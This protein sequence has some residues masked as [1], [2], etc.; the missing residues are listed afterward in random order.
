MTCSTRHKSHCSGVCGWSGWR[1]P[2]QLSQ[3]TQAISFQSEKFIHS[4]PQA[5]GQRP[6][7]KGQRLAVELVLERQQSLFV[8]HGPLLQ[9]APAPF[10]GHLLRTAD[11]LR[12]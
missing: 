2:P 11:G 6:K 8:E 9:G 5:K 1:R 12:L 3:G 4:R 10:S 7:A